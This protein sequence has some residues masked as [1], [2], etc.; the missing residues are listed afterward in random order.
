MLPQSQRA[1]M[2]DMQVIATAWREYASISDG[3]SHVSGDRRDG[4]FGMRTAPVPTTAA[5]RICVL[6]PD[7]LPR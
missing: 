2:F 3:S 7:K 6:R 4:S 5:P 1:V